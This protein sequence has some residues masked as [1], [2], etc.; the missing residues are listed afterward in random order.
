MIPNF[1]G[2]HMPDLTPYY[3]YMILALIVLAIL[4]LGTIIYR[5]FNQRVRGRRG[6]RLGI[7]EYH[8]LDKTRRLVLVR[9]D[10]IEHLILIGGNQEFV[11][12]SGI[13][14]G[15]NSRPQMTV[16]DPIPMRAP[17]RPAVFGDRV[18]PLR[19]VTPSMNRNDDELA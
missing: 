2:H 16:N 13:E 10:D 19:P 18:S 14:T 4:I 9:R 3:P 6:A 5:L 12:E 15:L 11:I 1:G 7:S 17:P 8:E